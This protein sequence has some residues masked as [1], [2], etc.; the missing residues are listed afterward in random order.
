MFAA[1]LGLACG[2][3]EADP[4]ESRVPCTP[5]E[6]ATGRPRSIEEAR[7]LIN[8]LPMPVTAECFAESLER[9]LEIEV[10]QSVFSAQ[11]AVGTRSPRIFIFSDP[12]IMTIVLE[13]EGRELLEFGEFVRERRSTRGEIA[14][15]VEE[16]L[17]PSAPYDRIYFNEER[18]LT[19]CSFCHGL[20]EPHPS[21]AGAFM[22]DPLRPDDDSLL[23]IDVLAEEHARCDAKAEPAR[24]AYLAAIVAHGTLEHRAFPDDMKT[25]FD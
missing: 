5:G 19:S 24:C 21:I 18:T 17:T 11:P 12:L 6:G 23:P 13:G 8:S 2:G 3:S 7:E 10:S 4:A 16:P 1:L 14:F 15:P 25:I 22:S 20:E 9:P